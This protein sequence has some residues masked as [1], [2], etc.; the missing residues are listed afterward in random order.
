MLKIILHGG[1]AGIIFYAYRNLHQLQVYP[2]MEKQ[3][4]GSWQ[5]LTIQGTYL[6]GFTMVA[7]L[8]LDIYPFV[9]VLKTAKRLLLILTLPLNVVISSVYWS[10]ALFMPAMILQVARDSSPSLDVEMETLFYV[11]LGLDIALHVVPATALLLDFFV[12][13]HKYGPK[14]TK[15]LAPLLALVYTVGYGWWVEHCGARNNGIFPYPFLTDN[16]LDTRLWIYGGAG[17]IAPLSF[18]ML[19]SLHP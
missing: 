2:L 19:N 10:L 14:T 1:A 18:W 4:G 9:D 3:Y 6:A 8:V 17:L 7:S 11:P 15:I 5:Y 12:F 13:E 16:P